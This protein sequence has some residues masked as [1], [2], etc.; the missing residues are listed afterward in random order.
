MSGRWHIIR[1]NKY[2]YIKG[3]RTSLFLLLCSM[4]LNTVFA[5]LIFYT[6]L[7]EPESE[8]YATNGMTPP[9]LLKAMLAPNL[10]SVAMLDPDPVIMEQNKAIP[11]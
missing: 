7:H 8:Y 3:Y 9:V 2:F 4:I 11:Q 1:Q 6:Y 10:S 5:V